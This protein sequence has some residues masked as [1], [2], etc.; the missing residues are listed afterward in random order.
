MSAE[1]KI[2]LLQEREALFL[3]ID[4]VDLFVTA[5]RV[6]GSDALDC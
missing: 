3:F 4:S 5:V 2:L 1:W 6:N